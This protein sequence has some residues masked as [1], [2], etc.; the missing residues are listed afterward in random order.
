MFNVFN[1]NET[2]TEIRYIIAYFE[3]GSWHSYMFYENIEEAKKRP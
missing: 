1:D 3:R 2:K